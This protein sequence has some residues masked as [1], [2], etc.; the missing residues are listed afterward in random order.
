MLG[1][2]WLGIAVGFIGLSGAAAMPLEKNTT[3]VTCAFVG[4]KLVTSLE[5]WKN[6]DVEERKKS[7]YASLFVCF[8]V[9]IC[10]LALLKTKLSFTVALGI[11][12]YLLCGRC[13]IYVCRYQEY[14]SRCLWALSICRN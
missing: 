9:M 4:F 8:I 7:T 6:T 2:F 11:W 12:G 14:K 3:L 10:I 1:V 5:L 13:S